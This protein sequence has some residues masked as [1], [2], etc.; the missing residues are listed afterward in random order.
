MSCSY[1]KTIT[2]IVLFSM[3][4]IIFWYIQN[5]TFLNSKSNYTSNHILLNLNGSVQGF[6]SL[7]AYA[8][9]YA[10]FYLLFMNMRLKKERPAFIV[11]HITRSKFYR[12]RTVSILA[13]SGWFA[14]TISSVNLGLTYL[15]VG[16]KTLSDHQ[17]YL[18]ILLNGVA[19][20]FFYGWIGLLE[21]AIE[22]YINSF[23]VAVLLT[24]VLIG[25]SYFF[26]KNLVLWLP[27]KDMRVSEA[28]LTHEWN[29]VDVMFVFLRQ[30]GFVVAIYLLGSTIFNKKDF[31]GNEK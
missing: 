3:F 25:L 6:V 18:I 10:L 9:Y 4:L 23:N 11:T 1:K 31:I 29:L 15:F 14:F 24:F 16:N 30:M 17:F 2:L 12:L 28:L 13:S 19:I 27:I 5:S 20:M 21:K 7:L 8:V 22:D 26:L